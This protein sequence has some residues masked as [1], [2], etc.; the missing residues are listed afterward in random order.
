LVIGDHLGVLTSWLCDQLASVVVEWLAIRAVMYRWVVL[1]DL[2]SQHR[3]QRLNDLFWGL[4][5][6]TV[7]EINVDRRVLGLPISP[8]P[9]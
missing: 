2:S 9:S 1:F 5:I 4:L 8:T 6:K 7:V 3:I